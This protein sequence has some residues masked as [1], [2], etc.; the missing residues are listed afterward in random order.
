[1][2]INFAN[3]VDIIG[4]LTVKD[5]SG[6]LDLENNQAVRVRV[7]NLSVEPSPAPEGRIIYNTTKGPTDNKGRL[8][9]KSQ[10]GWIYPD[11]E[12]SVYDTNNNGKVDIAENAEKLNGQSQSFYLDRAN[13]TGTQSASTIYDFN[14]AAMQFLRSAFGNSSTVSWETSGTPIK[15]DVICDA[16]GQLAATSSGLNLKT[17]FPQD[18]TF[19][20]CKVNQYGVV[21]GGSTMLTPDDISDF[22]KAVNVT[23]NDKFENSNT[24]QFAVNTTTQKVKSNVVLK[25]D[26]GLI[27]T[28]QGIDLTNRF[29]SSQTFAKVTVNQKGIVT[30]GQVRI[31]TSDINDFEDDVKNAAKTIPLNQF[32]APT[33]SINLNNQKIIGLGSPTN[34]TDAA[35]KE[36]VDMMATGLKVKTACLVATTG[37]VNL[38]AVTKIDGVTLL[39]GN[40]VLVKDQTTTSQ[41]GIYVFESGVG[42]QRATD[43]DSW[44][45][46][47]GAYVF[48][49]EG[50]TNAGRSY[51]CSVQPG[52]TLGVTSVQW[53]LFSE[54]RVY[55]FNNPL[56]LSGS[57]VSLNY[58]TNTLNLDG[59]NALNAKLDASKGLTSS[60]SGIRINEEANHFTYNSG[61][62]NLKL[63][64]NGGL[65]A[66]T[67]GVFVST[68]TDTFTTSGNIIDLA[69]SYKNK[70]YAIEITVGT[71]AYTHQIVHNLNSTNVMVQ[72]FKKGTRNSQIIYQSVIP[73]I[74]IT[75]ANTVTITFKQNT[76]LDGDYKVVIM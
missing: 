65:S 42:L 27:E 44:D 1:M 46:L 18:V 73:D 13:H 50:S 54:Q 74:E 14:T 53:V 57:T 23:V 56:T 69:P 59:S 30:D 64:T 31:N 15:A 3:D 63:K 70:K 45:E 5:G 35:T 28:T 6:N 71:G 26:S 52:G 40:R 55:N 29:G 36:Y 66:D 7:E 41:N 61:K 21:I 48:I 47:V 11:M 76:L 51:W 34:S 20:R 33:G 39:N 32:A 16:S 58:N 9:F 25:S 4:N 68:N 2:A 38:D 37:N 24:V 43:A 19:Y 62:L 8:G 22:V 17:V 67:N 75:D 12:R 49:T 10:S 72:V 60:T